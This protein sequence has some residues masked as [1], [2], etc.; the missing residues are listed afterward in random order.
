MNYDD[1][2]ELT[3]YVW[4]NYFY[5]TT[6]DER[7][8]FVVVH[9]DASSSTSFQQRV[10]PLLAKFP[11]LARDPEARSALTG[12]WEPFRRWVCLRILTGCAD[13]LVINR[14]PRCQRVVRTPRAQQCFWCGHD[15]H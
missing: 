3:Q 9:S 10:A 15:W 7:W 13:E 14:C 12:G 8:V 11:E 4:H 5:L 2:A 1:E 6:K